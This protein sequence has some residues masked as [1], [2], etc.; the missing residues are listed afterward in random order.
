[1]AEATYEQLL[2]DTMEAIE[3]GK[4]IGNNVVLIGCSTGCSLIHI[5]LAHGQQIKSAIYIS[6]NF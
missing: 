6:P 4:S 5:A 1:L 2:D 3:I